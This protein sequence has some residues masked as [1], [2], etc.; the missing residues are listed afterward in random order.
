MVVRSLWER[1]VAGSN[2]S[3][4]TNSEVTLF[5]VEHEDDYSV[6][7]V[8]DPRGIYEDV[9]IFFGEG[10][11]FMKQHINEEVYSF[12]KMTDIMFE[13]MLEAYNK[14]EGAYYLHNEKDT[15]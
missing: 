10:E 11:V 5:T 9:E 13:E 14:P 2:P 12:V 7:Q 3:T 8:L 15:E 1:E 4:P 6:I